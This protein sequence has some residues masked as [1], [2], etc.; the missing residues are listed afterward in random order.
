MTSGLYTGTGDSFSVLG[1]RREELEGAVLRADRGDAS[2]PLDV[3]AWGPSGPR[4]G[5]L[6]RGSDPSRR[7]PAGHAATSRSWDVASAPCTLLAEG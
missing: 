6:W 1:T 4:M 2:G 7:A 5:G 3:L